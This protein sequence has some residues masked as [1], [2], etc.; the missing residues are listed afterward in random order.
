MCNRTDGMRAPAEAAAVTVPADENGAGH[1][2]IC[3]NVAGRVKRLDEAVNSHAYTRAVDAGA[4]GPTHD[5]SAGEWVH[6]WIWRNSA[7]HVLK[8]ISIR[9]CR[10][11]RAGRAPVRRAHVHIARRR[12]RSSA[13]SCGC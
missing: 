8:L 1:C 9:G 11:R 10:C 4:P 7:H 5:M 6:D 13:C 2:I 3:R 12:T